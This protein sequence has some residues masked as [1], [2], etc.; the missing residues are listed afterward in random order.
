MKKSLYLLMVCSLLSSCGE[1]ES[2]ASQNTSSQPTNNQTAASTPFVPTHKYATVKEMFDDKNNYPSD[3]GTFKL[4]KTKPPEFIIRPQIE[5]RES[6]DNAKDAYKYAALEALLL[7]F[8]QTNEPE[9][10]FHILPR[11]RDNQKPITD[12]SRQAVKLKIT[13]HA[14]RE[15]VENALHKMQIYSLDDLIEHDS[16][17]QYAIA[18]H[19]N[20]DTYNKL[21]TNNSASWQLINQ[22]RTDKNLIKD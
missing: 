10:T 3:D 1:T 22:F 12:A 2:T 11:I 20:S 13:L 14:K 17:N 5:Q 19:S 16:S 21:R 15:D 18:G 6:I 9:I 4:I 7:T 8:A